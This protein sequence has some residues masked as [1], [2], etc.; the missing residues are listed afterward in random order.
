MAQLVNSLDILCVSNANGQMVTFDHDDVT[1]MIFKALRASGNPDRLLALNLADK[2]LYRLL[3]MRG[4]GTS[5]SLN[6][7]EG[8]IKFV[9]SEAGLNAA[10]RSL[11]V[12]S[13]SINQFN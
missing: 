8:M 1:C 11:E 13:K 10:G 7:V 12:A 4:T 3:N 5:L 2:V 6:D 9:F